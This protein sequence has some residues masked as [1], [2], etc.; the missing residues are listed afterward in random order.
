M[1]GVISAAMVSALEGL[2]LLNVFDVIYGSSAGAMN[3]AF[4]V[5]GQAA[6]G[7]TIYYENINNRRFINFVRAAV[8][9]P[10]VNL[11]FLVWD[12]MRRAK[13]L[14]ARRVVQDGRLRVVATNANTA[15]AEI[16]PYQ[17]D[18]S[19]LHAMRASATMPVM[20]GRAYGYRGVS[21]FDAS[22]SSPIPV[23]VAEREG[24]THVLAL[25][26]RPRGVEKGG[27][28]RFES[29]WVVPRLRR[30][31]DRLAARCLEAPRRYGD[32][33]AAVQSGIGPAG[34]AVVLGLQPPPP[35]L[36]KL[37]RRRASL[38]AAAVG[39]VRSVLDVFAPHDLREPGELLLR[40]CFETRR[41]RLQPA[42]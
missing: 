9:R 33:V 23:D 15:D 40:A 30:Y 16:V 3:A 18:E 7:T 31:S 38:V 34:R 1:R 37:E 32:I 41:G 35:A 27:L 25:L 4:F 2:G 42:Q 11:D 36:G 8:G 20:A 24:A 29:C 21:Y 12:V 22:L 26:T 19:L 10:V 28:S 14:D 17:D 39:G 6:F 13:M 5:A